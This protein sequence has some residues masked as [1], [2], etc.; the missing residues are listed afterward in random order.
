M[1][2]MTL[3]AVITLAPALLIAAA[4][5]AMAAD[6]PATHALTPAPAT[7]PAISSASKIAPQSTVLRCEASMS[8]DRPMW[9]RVLSLGLASAVVQ[10]KTVGYVDIPGT[11]TDAKS[12]MEKNQAAGEIMG[13]AVSMFRPD[14]I[15]IRTRCTDAQG[16]EILAKYERKTGVMEYVFADAKAAQ[17]S[18]KQ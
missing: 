15:A 3:T 10:D 5:P 12:V 18:T 11:I 2:K 9:Q 1:K 6:T 13:G 4:V 8:A 14:V 17:A 16:A 7:A